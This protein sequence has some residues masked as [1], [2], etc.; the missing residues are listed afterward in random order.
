MTDV[1][2]S[3]AGNRL[4]S[5]RVVV[6]NVGPW[7]AECVF[8]QAPDV[9]GAVVIDI[10]TTTLHGTIVPASDGTHALQRRSRVV[11]GA[12]GW[13]SPLTAR[14]YHSDAGVK[15]KLIAEDAAREV[16]ESIGTFVPTAERVGN[17]YVRQA[18]RASRTLEDVIGGVPWWLDFAGKTN[19]G[20]RPSFA[21]DSSA[22]QVMAF[23][24]NNRIATIAVDDPSVIQIGAVLS[25]DLDAPQTIREYEIRITDHELRITAWCGG[26]E[27][28]SGRLA[29][30]LAAIARRATDGPLW[31]MWRYRVVRMAVD[32]RVEL[33]A[34]RR[35]AGLP[36]VAPVSMWPGVAGA[37]AELTPGAE[38]VVEF[39]EGDRT[40]P[41]IT[42]FAGK[43]GVGFV[44][45]SL[46][47]C[48]STQAAARQGDLT[49][50]GGAGTVCV[51]TPIPPAVPAPPNGA[52]VAGV[53]HLISFGLAAVPQA[54]LYGAISSGSPKVRV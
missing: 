40:Q 15:A 8:E 17:D 12:A 3:I 31:G 44:P 30:L 52:V 38:V 21:L 53:P 37:H 49:Q 43:D 28:S 2:A 51:L 23:D 45:A 36:D 26:G 46:A 54:P 14:D 13:G 18:A 50:S 6:G 29:G 5:L 20:T 19:V 48:G 11:G 9:S 35:A 1:S 25:K 33:Q 34:V 4:T 22:Y 16:G 24:P 42:H 7:I 32:G 27:A 41:V 10:G 47:F 39:V